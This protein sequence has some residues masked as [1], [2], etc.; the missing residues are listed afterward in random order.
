MA[1]ENQP[2]AEFPVTVTKDE[3]IRA[4]LLAARRTGALRSTPAVVATA[5]LVLL[6]GVFSVG[7]TGVPLSV[8]IL[9]CALCP[10]I[11][12]LFFVA[13]PGA[14]RRQ[15]GR[16][17]QTYAALLCPATLRIFP[18]NVV[19]VAPH[20]TLTDQYALM[21]ECIET[22]ELLVFLKDRERFLVLPKRCMPEEQREALLEQFRITFVRRR[23]RMS[24]WLF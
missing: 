24:N 13:E 6:L 10:L 18:D 16:D 7:W 20:L 21:P 1:Y 9:F 11:L 15:A 22:P 17:Y 12:L 14:V 23:R 5:A 8:S 4:A 19:T 3:Y 2:R